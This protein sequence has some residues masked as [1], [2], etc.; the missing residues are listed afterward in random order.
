M[1]NTL[2]SKS[3]FCVFAN[4]KQH[5]FSGTPEE[6][7]KQFIGIWTDGFPTRSCAIAY[8]ISQD[9]FE[10]IHAVLEDTKA[11]R[12]TVI[13][14]AFH[15]IHIEPTKGTK[16]DAEDYIHKRG[17]FAESDEKILYLETH[18]SI[19]ANV[20]R[21][22]DWEEI[23]E[24]LEQGLTPNEIFSLAFKY[25][26]HEKIVRDAYYQKRFDETPIQRDITV[27][28]H[29]G[30]SGTGKSYEFVK[31]CEQHGETN[32][33]MCNDYKAGMD[34]YNGEKI[35]FMDEFRGQW[36]YAQL[37]TAL[38][39]YKTQFH[40]R[41]ANVYALWSEVHITSI[42]PP[43]EV[44]KKMVSE[45]ER[46]SDPLSQLKRRINYM[47]YHYKLNGEYLSHSIPM[48]D[49]VDYA[50]LKSAIVIEDAS[51]EEQKTIDGLFSKKSE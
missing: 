9:G 5:G 13:Q 19:R 39:G 22:N 21:S 33:Y 50:T 20:Q 1:A 46:N 47:V 42:M 24:L 43:D 51:L 37:L 36:N 44:Y 8:C 35:L 11:M 18:G 31:L 26:K 6:I 14:K 32:L 3:W 7:T 10:H 48:S 29:V 15:G 27:Y 23:E 49:Y 30:D 16:K 40:C 45:W 17:K 4:P 2:V 34:K 38:H 41:Y 12:Y 28:W 25:R